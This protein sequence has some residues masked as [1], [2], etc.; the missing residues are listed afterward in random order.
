MKRLALLCLLVS[1]FGQAVAQD[2]AE[3]SPI[4]DR[5]CATVEMDDQLRQRWPDMASQEEFEAWMDVKLAEG[6]GNNLAVTNIPVV[7]HVIHNGEAVGS[8]NNISLTYLNAQMD[9]LN[10]DFRKIAGTSGDNSNPVGADTEVSWVLDSVNRIDRNTAGFSAPPYTTNYIENTIK[11]ATYWDPDSYCNIWVVPISGGILGYAQFP[12]QSGLGGLGNDEGPASTDGVVVLTSSV[13]ST[14][15]PYPGGGAYNKGRTLTHELGHWLGL[16]HIWGDGGCS[17]DDYVTDTPTSDG[18]N[19]GCPNTSSCGST[20]MVE[21]YMDYTDDSCMNIFTSGQKSRIQTVL[22]N[23]LRR[24]FNGGGGGGGGDCTG[25]TISSFPYNEGFESG[26]GAWTQ[27][28]GDDFDWSRDS[29]GTPSSNTGPS[30]GSGSTWYMYTE[31]SSP[32]YSN[33]TATFNSPCFDLS[34]ETTA[35]FN[36]DYHM[37]GSSSMGSLY[38]EASPNGSTSWTTVW[39]R[40]SNQGNS[41]QSAS[42]NLDSYAGDVVQLRFRGVTGTTWQGDMAID[43]LN[44]TTSGGGGGGGETFTLTINLD[45]YPEETSWDL[46]DGSTVIASGG[47][48]GSQPDGSTVTETINVS[49]AGCY[50]F[51]IYDSYGDGICCGYGNG[52]YSLSNGSSVVAS[53]GSFGSSEST[54]VCTP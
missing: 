51:T 19:Y 17:V 36:F 23:S 47:T 38:L 7:F 49:S 29:N 25:T 16:R 3:E 30:S 42:V 22:A 21:N 12:S 15:T 39:S 20:D 18:A 46:K 11:G 27:D 43:N 52:S 10:N 35:T 48:Y 13:G 5:R 37:Y 31:S 45:N 6:A 32:N 40:S 2:F 9:Q 26:T 50:T 1:V 8:G 28:G 41:W 54:N 33:K 14:T 34:G 24:Q 44:L 4:K 53:G